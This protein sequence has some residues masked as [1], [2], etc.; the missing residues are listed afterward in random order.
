MSVNRLHTTDFVEILQE[1]NERSKEPLKETVELP[2]S[3]KINQ[4][5]PEPAPQQAPAQPD[6]GD[7][8][9]RCHDSYKYI[10]QR[11]IM[12]ERDIK[13]GERHRLPLSEN[14]IE[15]MIT[16]DESYNSVL[17]LTHLAMCIPRA[18]VLYRGMPGT[19]KTSIAELVSETLLGVP[20]TEIQEATIYGNPEHT[21]S[22]LLAYMDT[23]ALIKEGKEVIHPRKFMTS[24]VHMVDEVNRLSPGKLSIIYQTVDRGFATLKGER[25]DSTPGPFFGTA[26]YKDSGNFEMPPSFLDR[27]H[28]ALTSYTLNPAMI[29]VA[30]ALGEPQSLSEAEINYIHS[31]VASL[32][33]SESVSPLV[34][35]FFMEVNAC[36]RASEDAE[37]KTKAQMTQKPPSICTDC[38]YYT[39]KAICNKTAEGISVRAYNSVLSFSKAMAWWRGNGEI[40]R[41]DV[42]AVIPYVFAHRLAPT[43]CASQEHQ[44]DSVS[45]IREL[46]ASARTAY[47]NAAMICPIISELPHIAASVYAGT[48]S[49][50]AQQLDAAL[51]DV[52]KLQ[53]PAK[54]AIAVALYDLKQ[55]L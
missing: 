55:R 23:A 54:F 39:D 40:T 35:Y 41:E 53:T 14:G 7:L 18:T 44:R 20:L 21:T 16:A 26:N 28:V 1:L 12:P 48:P 8:H 31:E 15:Y 47:E 5:Q 13:F 33:W 4:V 49:V 11:L 24:R 30:P 19:G 29:G 27:F 2:L 34:M 36:W 52:K 43:S 17:L 32:A 22:E 37:R 42:E 45:F 3:T 51:N 25:I 50:T 38:H 10:S 6:M 46:F 9:A